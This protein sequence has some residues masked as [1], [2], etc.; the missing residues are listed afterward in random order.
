MTLLKQ[1]L[2]RWHK[3]K[4]K[5]TVNKREKRQLDKQKLKQ[6]PLL[7]RPKQQHKPKQTVN[8]LD[9]KQQDKQRLQPPLLALQVTAATTAMKVVIPLLQAHQVWAL[10]LRLPVAPLVAVE[11]AVKVVAEVVKVVVK[12]VAVAEAVKVEEV[13]VAHM[14]AITTMDTLNTAWPTAA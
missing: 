13:E 9:E 4:R 7:H 14:A 12:V 8:R 11:K 10:V 2:L 3:P 6:A 5:Q 1:G